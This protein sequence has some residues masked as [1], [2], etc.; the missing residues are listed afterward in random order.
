MSAPLST[1]TWVTII[2]S[3]G[4][5]L[6]LREILG[7]LARHRRGVALRERDRKRDLAVELQ[8]AVLR[9]DTAEDARDREVRNRRLVER[10][11]A[12][13]ERTLILHG[14]DAAVP[15][16]PVLEDTI[17]PAQMREL[18]GDGDAIGTQQPPAPA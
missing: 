2:G 7:G 9:A 14:L 18:R 12:H 11:A 13:M 16:E 17:T 8:R 10:R 3:G 5:V 15:P 1:D 6:I 4:G